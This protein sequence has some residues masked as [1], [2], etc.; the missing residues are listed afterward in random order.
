MRGWGDKIQVQKC[1]KKKKLTWTVEQNS[2]S[3]PGYFKQEGVL[4][5]I[6][7]YVK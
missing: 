2:S 6:N 7:S 1:E 3:R 4:L 5:A